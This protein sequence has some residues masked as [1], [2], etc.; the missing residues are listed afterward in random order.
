VSRPMQGGP[1]DSSQ[2]RR[3][4]TTAAK[5]VGIEAHVSLSATP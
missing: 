2:V 3:I 5:R 1:L 4:V